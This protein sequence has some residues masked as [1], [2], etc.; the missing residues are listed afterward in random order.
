MAGERVYA[1]RREGLITIDRS[2]LINDDIF[3]NGPA[4]HRNQTYPQNQTITIYRNPRNWNP[5]CE[6]LHFKSWPADCNLIK[7]I[8]EKR[9][10][11]QTRIMDTD[12]YNVTRVFVFEHVI[13]KTRFAVV[14]RYNFRFPEETLGMVEVFELDPDM[15]Y[16]P[17]WLYD[18]KSEP[19]IE[20]IELALEDCQTDHVLYFKRQGPLKGIKPSLRK[21]HIMGVPFWVLDVQVIG[22]SSTLD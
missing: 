15:L 17:S 12:D 22:D 10:N 16:S 2:K 4:F 19:E 21:G 14:F 5:D 9:W 18:W 3:R 20:D 11:P 8:P 7:A 1:R 13:S 6:D